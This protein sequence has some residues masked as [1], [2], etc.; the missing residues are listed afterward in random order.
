MNILDELTNKL[1]NMSKEFEFLL[2]ENKKLKAQLKE[3]KGQHDLVTRNSQD[4]LMTIQS[5]LKGDNR[6]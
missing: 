3:L 2:K 6:I 5:K 1:N 4:M